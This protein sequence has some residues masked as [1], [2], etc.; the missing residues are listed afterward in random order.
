VPVQDLL[1][2]P[3]AVL[4]RLVMTGRAERRVRAR[5]SNEGYSQTQ[6]N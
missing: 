6:A 3:A 1:I 5:L 4:T 2:C